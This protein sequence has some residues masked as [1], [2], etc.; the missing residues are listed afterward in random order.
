MLSDERIAEIKAS[1]RSWALCWPTSPALSRSWI[2]A[3]LL[4][5]DA[6]RPAISKPKSLPQLEAG[7][8]GY[9]LEGA[10]IVLTHTVFPAG[11]AKAVVDELCA[12]GV[13]AGSSVWSRCIPC[14]SIHR[15]QLFHLQGV[16]SILKMAIRT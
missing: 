16:S 6:F 13:A 1:K 11:I 7:M 5:T 9:R 4:N 3:R 14:K 2:E 15:H 10:Q 12:N 8:G